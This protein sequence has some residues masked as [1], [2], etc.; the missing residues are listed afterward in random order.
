[1]VKLKKYIAAVFVFVFVSALT[2]D[3]YAFKN[4][5]RY[6]KIENDRE[7]IVMKTGEKRRLHVSSPLTQLPVYK[8]LRFSSRNIFVA[9]VD[10]S[11][12]VRAGMCGRTYITVT[13]SKGR[14]DSILIIVERGKNS[15]FPAVFVIIF[16]AVSVIALLKLRPRGCACGGSRWC[17]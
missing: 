16:A 1:M 8:D 17:F 2:C 15:A 7:S 6:L 13:D 14:T 10:R 4:Y 11:G 9:V 3:S 12:V 5:G